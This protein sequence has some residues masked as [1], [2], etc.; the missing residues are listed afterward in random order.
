MAMSLFEFL[1]MYGCRYP[2]GDQGLGHF[3]SAIMSA[4]QA[5]ILYT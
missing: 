2:L 4:K 1:N 5:Y 3:L